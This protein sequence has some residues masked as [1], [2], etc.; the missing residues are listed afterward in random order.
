MLTSNRYS[1]Y[2]GRKLNWRHS[3]QL[4]LYVIYGDRSYILQQYFRPLRH[5]ACHLYRLNVDLYSVIDRRSL[6]SQYLGLVGHENTTKYRYFRPLVNRSWYHCRF[7]W[8]TWKRNSTRNYLCRYVFGQTYSLQYHDCEIT[9]ILTLSISK[10]GQF[11]GPMVNTKFVN[12]DFSLQKGDTDSY[13]IHII[14]WSIVGRIS[15]GGRWLAG[16]FLA[17]V[18][19]RCRYGSYYVLLDGR[20]I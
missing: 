7:V 9:G 17:L 16:N 19:V 12:Y 8:G 6:G 15:D 20:I 3:R 18:C 10:L 2:Y 13:H 5:T 1:N 4:V 14:D 11:A